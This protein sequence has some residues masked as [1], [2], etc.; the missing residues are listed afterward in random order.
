MATLAIEHRFRRSR[1]LIWVGRHMSRLVWVSER[2]RPE[3]RATQASPLP[4]VRLVHGT[5][6]THAY[7]SSVRHV[8]GPV[9]FMGTDAASDIRADPCNACAPIQRQAC[10]R[11]ASTAAAGEPDQG[12]PWPGSDRSA[13]R[14][15]IRSSDVSACSASKW[16][17]ASSICGPVPKPSRSNVGQ[18]I[19]GEQQAPIGH[20]EH[21]MA[22]GVARRVD[23]DRPSGEVQ[24]IAITEGGDTVQEVELH[25][26]ARD[27]R[28]EVDEHGG[29]VDGQLAWLDREPSPVSAGCSGSPRR[30]GPIRR[31]PPW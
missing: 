6:I 27:H 9:S 21:H 19:T 12:L 14:S 28:E 15:T 18:A 31:C 1:R 26:P 5:I 23:H 10:V 29:P 30:S 16:N 24:A 20:V 22:L 4:I 7:R 25:D 3:P 17:R 13:S 2:S 8:H 11:T